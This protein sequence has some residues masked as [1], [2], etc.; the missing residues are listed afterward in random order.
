MHSPREKK[1]QNT[2][3]DLLSCEVYELA[4][5]KDIAKKKTRKEYINACLAYR[6]NQ[7]SIIGSGPDASVRVLFA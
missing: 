7:L 6:Q 3:L 2:R 5:N 1:R 4:D